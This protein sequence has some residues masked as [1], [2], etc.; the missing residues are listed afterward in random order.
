MSAGSGVLPEHA[1]P[2]FLRNTNTVRVDNVSKTSKSICMRSGYAAH[3]SFNLKDA[4]EVIA[5]FNA[6]VGT[7]NRVCHSIRA[8][9]TLQDKF[10]TSMRLKTLSEFIWK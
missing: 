1:L 3:Y 4:S 5:L 9:Y 10:V 6:L 2:A 8:A 7:Y